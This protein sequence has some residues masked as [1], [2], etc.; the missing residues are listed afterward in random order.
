M[1]QL[2]N[3]LVPIGDSLSNRMAPFDE[4]RG[5]DAERRAMQ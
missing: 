2:R 3:D 1:T 5:L 4:S